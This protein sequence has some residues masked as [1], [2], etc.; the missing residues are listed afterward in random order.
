MVVSGFGIEVFA[1]GSRATTYQ[2]LREALNDVLATLRRSVGLPAGA[3]SAAPK[4]A[5]PVATADKFPHRPKGI[6]ATYRY[7]TQPPPFAIIIAPKCKVPY[8]VFRKEGA[9]YKSI[10]GTPSA[11]LLYVEGYLGVGEMDVS[12]YVRQHMYD[13]VLNSADRGTGVG[14]AQY[15]TGPYF[16]AIEQGEDCP[17]TFSRKKDSGKPQQKNYCY[18]EPP[19][20]AA[21]QS[22]EDRGVAVE[23]DES[24]LPETIASM[25]TRTVKAP[26]A[27]LFTADPYAFPLRRQDRQVT[28]LKPKKLKIAVEV[29]TDR[30]IE[31]A[32]ATSPKRGL[33]YGE[34]KSV[35]SKEVS[36]KVTG[37]PLSLNIVQE[38]SRQT[39]LDLGITLWIDPDHEDAILNPAVYTQRPAQPYVPTPAALAEVDFSTT[40]SDWVQKIVT[41]CS[42]RYG[43]VTPREYVQSFIEA[44][45]GNPTIKVAGAPKAQ[46]PRLRRN[47]A[48]DK[49]TKATLAFLNDEG[50]D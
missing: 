6:A 44:A 36:G 48:E 41:F 33:I 34:V 18:R 50:W 8:A 22:M 32:T 35:S 11:D 3:A 16:A 39:I 20:T 45:A 4:A 25:G 9:S 5:A 24:K 12:G 17:G 13:G 23:V 19:A 21:W 47:P 26:I 2:T 10:G 38:I 1:E 28:D 27:D 46:N 30:L 15:M 40:D 7:P 31:E 37:I 14:P 43:L 49:R 42:E 29:D